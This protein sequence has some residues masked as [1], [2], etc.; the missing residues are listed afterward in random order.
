M[1]TAI[2]TGTSSGI[3]KAC[4]L[5]FLE[6]GYRVIG[7]SRNN[8]IEHDNFVFIHC[9]LSDVYQIEQLNFKEILAADNRVVLINNAGILGHI[10]RVPEL[11]AE[12][13]ISVANVNIIA[14]QVLCAKLLQEFNPQQVD[15]IVN[16]S[17]GA[18]KRAIP[19]W[20]AYC[21]S[22][23]ALD[24][25]SETLKIELV[26]L[27]YPAKVYSVAPGVVDTAMQTHIRSAN[28]DNFTALPNF[29]ALKEEGNLRS[30]EEV[31]RLI[32]EL[33][34]DP[35]QGEVVTRV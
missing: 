27:G 6:L 17:S 20:A 18:A 19:S 24:L 11:N 35:K 26:E 22:K 25:F 2:I 16:I 15:C 1:K 9:D 8:S 12:H 28:E 21:A 33:V 4:A 13:F 31:A 23:A 34:E 10:D 5:R 7:I 3:G 29:I 30:P 32:S 14:P